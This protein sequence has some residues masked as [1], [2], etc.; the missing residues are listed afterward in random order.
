MPAPV[1]VT[2]SVHP[3][4]YGAITGANE[5]A[6]LPCDTASVEGRLTGV[7]VDGA[8]TLMELDEGVEK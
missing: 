7:N 3:D 4:K 5:R 1:H 8:S 6:P 2:V